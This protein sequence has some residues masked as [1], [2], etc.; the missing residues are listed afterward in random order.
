MG[1]EIVSRGVNET[2]TGLQ[3]FFFRLGQGGVLKALTAL[4]DV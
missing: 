2:G 3:G 4:L 1:E